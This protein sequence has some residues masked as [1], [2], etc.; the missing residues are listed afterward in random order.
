M[1]QK[2]LHVTDNCSFYQKK[3]SETKEKRKKVIA[4]IAGFP[5][6]DLREV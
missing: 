4:E 1:Q 2:P 6:V 3:E 5:T